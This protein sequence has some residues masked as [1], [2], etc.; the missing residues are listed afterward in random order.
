[1][2]RD[3]SSYPISCRTGGPDEDVSNHK[4]DC[5]T[6]GAVDLTPSAV[7]DRPHVVILGAGFGGLACA[8]ALG[9]RAVRVTIIDR[10]NYH[11]FV[12]LLYQVA[13][14]AL[15]P[16]DIAEPVRKVLRRHRNIDVVMGEVTGIDTDSRCVRLASGYVPYDR[17]VIATGSEYNYFGNDRW[18]AFAPGLKTIADA[19]KIRARVLRGFELA[20]I[21]KDPVEQRMLTTSVVVGGGPTGV[22]MAGA[23][24]ELARWSLRR[25][26]RNID[27]TCATTMLVEAGKRILAPFPEDLATYAS[28]RLEKMGVTVRTGQPV[29]DIQ[30][31]ALTIGGEVVRAR[32]IVWAA[33]VRAS[34]AAQ[35]LGIEADRLGRI[36]VRADLS[37]QG[38]TNVFAIGD[39]AAAMDEQGQ[40]LPGLAQVA[41][42]QGH[43]LGRSLAEQ[44]ERASPVQHFRFRNRGNTAVIGRS[45]AIFD[46]G[47][48]QL[49]GWLAWILWAIV[50][51]YLLVGFEKRLM[52]SFQWFWRWLTYQRG[53]RL[54]TD[55]ADPPAERQTPPA[56]P[57]GKPSRAQPSKPQAGFKTG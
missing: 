55:D 24:A 32:T 21:S 44:L 36:P 9:G 2:S 37:V 49:K 14:A 7:D 5:A 8:Q 13:T 17:L 6:E 39:V 40:P 18:K 1:M 23:I 4:L 16:A 10:H 20:E 28:R 50:H 42:Q 25:D 43:Y 56:A 52:V 54:I 35:W 34:P 22:E 27:P 29:E 48:R 30:E 47:T 41:K 33:G 38:C 51:V 45:A 11:L 12:P 3:R 53:V 46:F 26:F 15:S 19:R 31:S 57:A